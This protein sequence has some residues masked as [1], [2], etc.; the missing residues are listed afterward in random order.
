L[1]KSEGGRGI[2]E[3]TVVLKGGLKGGGVTALD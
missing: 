1:K 3:V 2:K